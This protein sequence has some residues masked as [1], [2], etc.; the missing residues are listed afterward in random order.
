VSRRLYARSFIRSFAPLTD[1]DRSNI[2]RRLR[3][4][5]SSA[6][7]TRS[8]ASCPTDR[9]T[10]RLVAAAA[11]TVAAGP[12]MRPARAAPLRAGQA[13]LCSAS[14]CLRVRACVWSP[15]SPASCLSTFCIRRTLGCERICRHESDPASLVQ[16]ALRDMRRQRASATFH[17]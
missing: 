10:K 8:H 9:P 11:S 14:V 6:A 4:Y 16:I 12:A 17:Q 5:H 3:V 1:F 13:R 7:T 15:H 2:D